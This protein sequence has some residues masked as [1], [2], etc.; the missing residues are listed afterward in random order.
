MDLLPEN[1]LEFLEEKE[2]KYQLIQ[3][4]GGMYLIIE[5]FQFPL[6]TPSVANLLI[7]I[8]P[9]YSNAPLDMFWTQPDVK[10]L[11]GLF[12]QA[13]DVYEPHNGTQWQRWSRH[14][15]WRIGIDNIR[16][17]IAAIKREL[18]KGI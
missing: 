2:Y 5:D 8:P 7:C 11:S 1:D 3:Y 18:A 12:P 10:L 13:S 16:T 4:E 17:Y 6:Y 14:S 9:G 15:T